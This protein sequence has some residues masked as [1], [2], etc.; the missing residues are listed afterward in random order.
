MLKHAILA[1]LKTWPDLSQSEIA[2]RIGCNQSV[3][4][5]VKNEVTGAH[6]LPD[7]VTANTGKS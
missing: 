1:A 7:P 5:R 6:T 2:E 3:V 4:A